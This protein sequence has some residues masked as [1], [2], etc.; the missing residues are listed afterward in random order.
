MKCSISSL[1]LQAVVFALFLAIVLFVCFFYFFASSAFAQAPDVVRVEE[2][3]ELV[4]ATPDARNAAPQVTCV[5]SPFSNLDGVFSTFLV[6]HR[7]TPTS[8]AGGLEL[9]AWNA[10]SRLASKQASSSDVLNTAQEAIRWTTVMRLTE[11]TLVFEVV[12]GQSATWGAFGEQGSLQITLNTQLS[13]FN[14][15]SADLSVKSSSVSYAANRV[16][17]L[18]LKSVRTY[19]ATGLIAEDSQGKVVH[20]LN[21]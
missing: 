12:N 16:Q 9:Q 11:G 13:N 8:M 6:N 7:N 17:S 15:Y 10:N 3:W 5:M 20:S 18:T 19:S 4:I 2:D 1:M 21:Q 14:G